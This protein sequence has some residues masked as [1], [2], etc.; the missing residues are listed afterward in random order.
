MKKTNRHQHK[1]RIVWMSR[2]ERAKEN[3]GIEENSYVETTAMR[4]CE[5]IG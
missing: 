4:N 3:E 5:A 2:R 1:K